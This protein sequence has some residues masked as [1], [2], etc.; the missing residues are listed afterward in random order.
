M[1]AN[2]VTRVQL[3]FVMVLLLVLQF[4][5]RPRLWNTRVSPDFLLIALLVKFYSN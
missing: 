5:I 4:Y 1:S 2:R 3:L